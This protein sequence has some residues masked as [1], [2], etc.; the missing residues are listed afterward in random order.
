MKLLCIANPPAYEH[1]TTD[2]PLSYERLAAHPEI[3]L[4]HA[5]TAAMMVSGQSIDIVP[6]PPGFT[7]DEFGQLPKQRPTRMPADAFHIA[8]CRTLKPFPDGY[9]TRL[10][11]WSQSVP[12]VNNPAGIAR[13]LDVG[14]L[15]E[16]ASAF[17]PPTRVTKDESV[18]QSFLNTHGTIVVKHSN[19]CGGRGVYKV[20]TT[21]QGAWVTDNVI[22]QM[23]VFLS[24]SDCFHHLSRG[25]TEAV[26]LMRY[27][28][29]VIEGD[30]RIVVMDGDIFGAFLRRS[31][32]GHWIQNVSFGSSCDIVPVTDADR[33][34]VSATAPYYCDAGIRLLGYDLLLDDDG[35]WKVSEIN[36]GNIGGVFRLESMGVLGTTNRFVEKLQTIATPKAPLR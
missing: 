12:F 14:F 17:T 23:R 19:S 36:A 24:F 22:E 9:L 1:A 35:S 7:A 31:P 13:Q 33:G 29:R 11:Q 20:S 21:T 32:T 34:L 28:P 18:A 3:E 5:D 26:L 15:L 16:A 10:L 4:F 25:G 8:F 27:L 30:K 2:I 6:I